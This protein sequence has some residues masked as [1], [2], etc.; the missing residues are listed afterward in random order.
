VLTWLDRV[1]AQLL[2]REDRRR[3]AREVMQVLNEDF[4]TAM[5]VERLHEQLERQ[6][7][8]QRANTEGTYWADR[9]RRRQ[10]QQPTQCVGM[11]ADEADPPLWVRWH[12]G[13]TAYELVRSR[14]EAAG[15]EPVHHQ[16]HL[17]VP[18]AIEPATAAAGRQIVSL[19]SQVVRLYRTAAALPDAG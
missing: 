6:Q 13:T 10:A 17:W 5:A 12:R 18:L 19:T 14:L 11:R 3:L 4:R 16:G 2:F 15:D 8:A 1:N 9:G 7:A